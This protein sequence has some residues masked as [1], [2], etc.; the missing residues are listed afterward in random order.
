MNHSTSVFKPKIWLNTENH[1]LKI[2]QFSGVLKMTIPNYGHLLLIIAVLLSS[3]SWIYLKTL[4]RE[5]LHFL[6]SSQQ[7]MEQLSQQSYQLRAER[8][9]LTS[10]DRLQILNK[11]LQI[12]DIQET[13][14][15]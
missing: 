7:K 13:I 12:P 11:H 9:R 5:K 4:Q 14:K 1:S 8:D 10:P 6:Q 3:L 15:L 2:I